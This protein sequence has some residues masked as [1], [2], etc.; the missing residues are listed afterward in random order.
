MGNE[1]TYSAKDRIVIGDL[2]NLIT[3]MTLKGATINELDNATTCSA[4]V[5]DAI[6]KGDDYDDVLERYDI[7]DLKKKYQANK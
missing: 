2:G 4:M 7:K 3:D 1:K 6:I 5:I